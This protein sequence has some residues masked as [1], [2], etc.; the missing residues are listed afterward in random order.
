MDDA[1]ERL[2]RGE[3]RGVIAP[4]FIASYL[5]T[6]HHPTRFHLA[7]T[8]PVTPVD[9]VLSAQTESSQPI[10]IMNKALADMQP[11]ALMQMAGDW[12]QAALENSEIWNKST[13]VNSL[14]WSILLLLVVVGCWLWIQYLRRALRRGTVWQQK[15]AEQLKFTQSLIDASPVALYVRDR[16]GNLLRYNQ[17]W[18]D[19]IGLSGQDLIGLPI[20]AIDT[21]EPSELAV[22]ESRYRQALQ[23]GQP[24][25]WSARFQIDEQPRYLQG[26]VVPWHDG[27]GEIG[28]LIGGWLDIT[29]K[30]LLIAQ[31]SET[32]SN[33]EQAIASKTPSC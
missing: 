15:L 3:V 8:L 23:D 33:L 29:E 5:V 18:S 4:Q 24:Q 6:L 26:W 17:A 30:E 7:V 28:G 2:K 9:L 25:N 10:N 20:T 1:L 31:L 13:L 32:K 21:I 11:R 27:Q 16:Q 12:R 14:L 19:T 22:I